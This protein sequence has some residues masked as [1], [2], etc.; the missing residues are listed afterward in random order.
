M[1]RRG[2]TEGLL[3]GLGWGVMYVYTDRPRG[4]SH[5]GDGDENALSIEGISASPYDS[6]RFP[7]PARRFM[8]RFSRTRSQ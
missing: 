2:V 7:N 1:T 4:F 6:R 5:A 3:W 8:A